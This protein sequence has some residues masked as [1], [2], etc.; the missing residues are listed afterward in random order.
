MNIFL[1]YIPYII[2][3]YIIVYFNFVGEL[4]GCSLQNQLHN[5]YLLKHIIGV[6]GMYMFLNIT[7]SHQP[8]IKSLLI[9]IPMYLLFLMNTRGDY[10]YIIINFVLLFIIY[11]IDSIRIYNFEYK[12]IDDTKNKLYIKIEKILFIIVIIISIIG[13][14]NHYY[15][16]IN[17]H[18]YKWSWNKFLSG[19]HIKC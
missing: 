2:I 15:N 3:F 18:K 1:D 19:K 14:I 16:I 9:S 10:H 11:Y 7:K 5:N 13:F 17:K 8:P 12:I 6:M 4:I